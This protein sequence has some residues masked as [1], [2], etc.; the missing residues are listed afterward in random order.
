[1]VPRRCAFPL[2]RMRFVGPSAVSRAGRSSARRAVAL[3]AVQRKKRYSPVRTAVVRCDRPRPQSGACRAPPRS[4][5]RV[6]RREM[7]AASIPIL[8]P[9]PYAIDSHH[10]PVT[11]ASASAERT[12][13]PP[14]SPRAPSS[15]LS[16]PY[17]ECR[18]EV[19]FLREILR[20]QSPITQPA[21]G[22]AGCFR[23]RPMRHLR[24]SP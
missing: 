2:Q 20:N 3:P 14:P 5:R 8:A 18:R 21:P 7:L 9:R 12:I 4:D 15:K 19:C 24:E 13:C 23:G 10:R 17:C 22:P 11:S 6:H 1:V 16:L